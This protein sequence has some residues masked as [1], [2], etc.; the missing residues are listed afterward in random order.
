MLRP[1]LI[2]LLLI[3]GANAADN[4]FYAYHTRLDFEDGISGRYADVIVSYGESGRVVFSRE[5][6]YLPRWETDQGVFY[7]KEVVKR[8]AMGQH[9]S[10]TASTGTPMYA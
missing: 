4:D 9:F 3:V 1:F 10:R 7:F 6:S 5:S 2:P 8:V